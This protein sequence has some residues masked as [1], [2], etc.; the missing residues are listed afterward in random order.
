M[1]CTVPEI[2]ELE[3]DQVKLCELLVCCQYSVKEY[4]EN[5]R[6]LDS[7]IIPSQIRLL[8]MYSTAKNMAVQFSSTYVR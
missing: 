4:Q 6:E 3:V 5:C 1:C 8:Y 7:I 2:S